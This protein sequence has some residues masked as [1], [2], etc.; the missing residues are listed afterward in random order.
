MILRTLSHRHNIAK[1]LNSMVSFLLHKQWSA[2]GE[3][4]EQSPFLA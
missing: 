3:T 1:E 4:P 2:S